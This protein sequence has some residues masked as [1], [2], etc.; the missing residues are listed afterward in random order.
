MTLDDPSGYHARVTVRPVRSRLLLIALGLGLLVVVLG[1]S[2]AEWHAVVFVGERTAPPTY[3]FDGH[4]RSDG[5]QISGDLSMFFPNRTA[6]NCAFGNTWIDGGAP[7]RSLSYSSPVAGAAS[8]ST[9]SIG[10]YGYRGPGTY[11]D[12][13]VRQTSQGGP[14]NSVQ[15]LP[16]VDSVWLNLGVG[17]VTV[18]RESREGLEGTVDADIEEGQSGLFHLTIG[19]PRTAHINGTWVCNNR[20]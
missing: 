2:L 8:F 19:R 16:S 10:I 3:R 20:S 13:V 12:D 14:E 9:V 15:I 6:G 5:V 1:G 17:R 18:T 4:V 11:E 7:R